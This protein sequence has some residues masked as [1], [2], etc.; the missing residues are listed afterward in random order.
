[1]RKL[2]SLLII[3]LGAVAIQAQKVKVFADP[4]VD[5]MKF[6][7]YSWARGVAAPNP[8]VNQLIIDAIDQALAA[9]GLTRVSEGADITVVVWA[10]LN[11]DLHIL[12]PT[13][14]RS[15]GSATA[16]GI[17]LRTQGAAVSKGTL[18]VDISD[19]RS[20]AMVWR[21]TST[22]TL[23]QDPSGDMARDAKAAEKPIRKAVEKMFKKYPR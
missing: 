3:L 6:K 9:K 14:G 22:Q 23:A 18:V 7:T 19:A 2:V 13:F 10:A 20:K 15:A 8:L 16:T 1:M 4:S 17:P 11:S 21:A 12:N 5:L